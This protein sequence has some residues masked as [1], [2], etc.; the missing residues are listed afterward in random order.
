MF[1]AH[2]GSNS[3]GQKGLG[4]GNRSYVCTFYIGREVPAGEEWRWKGDQVR[5]PWITKVFSSRES[6]VEKTSKP[7]YRQVSKSDIMYQLHKIFTNLYRF[8]RYIYAVFILTPICSFCCSHSCFYSVY[9]Y[10]Y[11]NYYWTECTTRFPQSGLPRVGHR[12]Y[13]APIYV[14]STNW[15]LPSINKDLIEPKRFG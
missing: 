13:P 12:V 5:R 14:E 11:R 8:P 9:I 3:L 1:I 15:Y 6:S 2:R 7:R 10:L 4:G